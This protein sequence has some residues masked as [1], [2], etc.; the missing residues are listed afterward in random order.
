MRNIFSF[1]AGTRQKTIDYP[2]IIILAG[3]SF[4]IQS[5]AWPLSQ[6]RDYLTY[7]IYYLDYFDV[8]PVYQTLMLYRTPVAPFFFG[9]TLQY[10]GPTITEIIMGLLFVTAIVFIYQIGLFWNRATAILGA[11]ALLIY[12]PYGALYHTASSDAPFAFIF[13]LWLFLIISSIKSPSRRK[14]VLLGF[15]FFLLVLTRPT[16]QI[17]LAFC[18]FPLLFIPVP[19]RTRMVY[20]LAFLG[21]SCLLLLLWSTHNYIRY[22]DFTVSRTGTALVPLYR[23]FVKDRLVKPENGPYSQKLADLVA[24]D[25]LTTEPYLSYK[26]DLNTFFHPVAPG[27]I[28]IL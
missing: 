19:I 15:V 21:T 24:T 22:D 20:S 14:F 7:I 27:C 11:S 2:V 5:L 9:S 6:G 8:K 17:Y 16:S 13:L 23:V 25:L 10:L 26:I 28:V 1:F 3:V 4:F 18:L 12:P